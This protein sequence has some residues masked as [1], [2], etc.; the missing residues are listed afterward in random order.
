MSH[1]ISFLVF[2]L[3][4]SGATVDAQSGF[5]RSA[6]QPIPGATVT[7]TQGSAKV[8]TTT[9]PD[10]SYA[11]PSMP[12]GSWTVTVQ[13][14]GF[15][16]AKQ[17]VAFSTTPKQVD[18]NLQLAPSALAARINRFASAR[19]QQSG[20]SIDTQIQNELN[21]NQVSQAAGQP[22][23]G[24]NSNEAFLVAGSLSQGLAANAAPDSGG[25][26][27]QFR[28]LEGDGS[29]A[30]SG[31][32]NAPGFGEG[33]SGGGGFG[34]GRGGFGGGG[35]GGGFG[36][37]RGG[38]PRRAGA[39]PRGAFGNRRP[40]SQIHG[41]AFFTL[42]NSA[43]NAQPFSI[44][45]QNISQPAY[46]QSRIGVLL[47]GPLAIPKIVH[48]PSTFFFLSYFATRARN[49]YTAVETVPSDLERQ[50]N[51]S[52]SI[53]SNGPGST[54]PVQLYDPT[55]RQPFPGNVIPAD[56]LNPIAQKLLNFFPA[57]NQPGFVNNYDFQA[58]VP[59]NTDNIG[60]R[61][62]RNITRR[63][64]L[65]YR[66][67][68]QRRGGD[69]S[70]PF[71]F[72]DTTGG[73]GISTSLSWT[74]NLSDALISNASVSF[75]RNR[76]ETN[77]FFANGSDIA[78]EFGI[79]GTSTNPRN[80]GPPNLNFTNFGALSDGTPIITRNQAQTVGES[81]ILNRGAHTFTFGM[82]FGRN[83]LNTD[84]DQNGRGTFNF[85]G[86]ATSALTANGTPVPGTG[87]DLADFLLGFPQSS[88][89]RYGDSSTYFRQNVWSGYAQDDWK[90]LPNL[91]FDVGL[92]YEYFSPFY[93]KYGRVA[94]L[95]IAPGFDAVSVVI[96]GTVGAYTGAFPFGLINP[97]Y[98]NFAPRVALAWKVPW[99]KS[100]TVVRS[101]Y[102][103]YYNG[104]AYNGFALKLA[105]Q[106]PFAVS[107]GVNT[108]PE[109][110]LTLADGFVST[111]PTDVTNTYAIDRN[112]RTPYAQT[113]NFTIQHD[114]PKG[115]FVELG[116]LGTK[117]TH[118]DVDTLPNVGPQGAELTAQH[119][120][121][122]ASGF[123]YDS[124]VG[125]S[126]YNGMHVRVTQ[127]FRRGLSWSAYYTYSKSIDDSST[128]GGAGNT[129]AQN[130][131]DIAAER[132]LSSFDHR[133]SFDMN[134][135]LT[136][137]IGSGHSRFAPD[138]VT[139]RL[140]KDWQLSGSITAQTGTPL[141][142]RVLGNSAK[143]AQTA[144]VGS[145]RANATG[146]DLSS[147]TDF[148][149]LAAFTVPLPGTFGNAGRNTIPG[150]S[151]V[152]LNLTFGRGFQIGGESRRRLELR[153]E[154]NNVLNHV[155]YTNLETVVNATNYGLPISTSS[156][157]TLSIVVRF[158]F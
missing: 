152:A 9:G 66:L 3:A 61:V 118:L 93:E 149:N 112:Y 39:R 37:P 36:G 156:M 109:N 85:T 15:T 110:V 147:S 138:S 155:N 132:G 115:I 38:G 158:R 60:L 73:S 99:F 100:S 49:P 123:T 104:Q 33:G 151:D 141:T 54:A 55:T 70:Q 50:G 121:G 40:P 140:L 135:V 25:G 83:D 87:F 84:T 80:F 26:A 103:I 120:L 43:L 34:G 114:L 74:H 57:P 59:Q 131:L 76:N 10:G 62:M 150:P 31:S 69:T 4:V 75:N 13:M 11:F 86:L 17:E 122:N 58:S 139:A 153:L 92:R 107:N 64:R 105:Q 65:A 48:D 12:S 133:H 68:Y 94:N 81:I 111:S 45:G 41:M 130:W 19:G 67:T 32:A 51:F 144:G 98:K 29:A 23:D 16:P 72:L 142:A 22:V 148:F 127:R 126:I 78:A 134:G 146:Q 125:N 116:Y 89:I 82:Q 95:D 28:G 128:F 52:Q 96:P 27:Q 21:A 157:R 14:F 108:S 113:W 53:Q 42:N 2:L 79:A 129:V 145:G 6:N 154:A 143:L 47:G 117:G 91:T 101:G 1:A 8:V 18:F 88:S 102:G 20:N 119:Q 124:S 7:A 137:P 90:V 46:A 30:S 5:V 71:G 44:T 136:S 97:D 56:R 77:P 63:D 106:P 24:Q 35:R